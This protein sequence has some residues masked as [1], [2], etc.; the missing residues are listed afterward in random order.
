MGGVDHVEHD[1]RRARRERGREAVIGALF[2]LLREGHF[3]PSTEALVERSGVSL[4]SIFRYFENIDDLQQQTIETH[5]DQFAPLFE[6]PAIG[7]GPLPERIKRLAD[8]RLDLYEAIAPI[9][10]LARARALEHPLIAVSLNRSRTMLT[11]QIGTH[12]AP[13][14]GPRS[15]AATEDLV[16]LI[17]SLTSFEVWDLLSAGDL[18]TRPQI[19]R[20]WITGLRSLIEIS[21]SPSSV[22]PKRAAATTPAST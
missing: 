7:Q 21:P 12:F 18:R 16:G 1:G 4:S 15:P 19:R 13:E 9:A 11:D 10:R 5:F 14:I 22:G 17:A 2:A 20:A 6:V 8:A 3:P